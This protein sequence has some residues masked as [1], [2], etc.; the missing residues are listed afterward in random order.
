MKKQKTETEIRFE[1]SLIKFKNKI[2]CSVVTFLDA[3]S[4]YSLAQNLFQRYKE[5]LLSRELYKEKYKNINIKLK[6]LVN[7]K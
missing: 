3:R 2:D 1:A 7:K 5:I 4:M 6:N